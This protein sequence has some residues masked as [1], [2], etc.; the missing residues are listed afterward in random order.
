MNRTIEE[1]CKA[2]DALQIVVLNAW[3]DDRILNEVYGWHHPSLTRHDLANLPRNLSIRL[4]SLSP[5]TIEADLETRIV[6]IPR[7]LHSLHSIIPHMYNGNGAQAIPA[8][9]STIKA[10]TVL[11]DPL[12]SWEVLADNKAMPPQLI[13]KLRGIQA[14]IENIIPEKEVLYSQIKLINDATS[15]A[16]SLPADLQSLTEARKKIDDIQI[17]SSELFNLIDGHSKNSTEMYNQLDERKKE[18]DK[19]V[20]KCEEA[21]RITTTHGLASAFEQRAARLSTTMWV[22]VGGLLSTLIMGALLGSYRIELLSNEL[23]RSNPHWGIIVIHI[24]IS[25]LSIGA[26]IWFAWLATKQIGQRFRLS[27]DYA[28]KASVAKAYEGYRKEAVRIDQS[29][30]SRLF[31]SA[32][33]RLEEAPLRLIEQDAHGSPWHELFGSN[34]LKEALKTTP[35]LKDKILDLVEK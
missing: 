19:L 33:T 18:A 27:E 24:I 13:K 17:K 22:W 4:K 7:K 23:S 32:L 34:K 10:V 31:G 9:I 8:Y 14:E 28:F 11:L 5:E 25:A 6:D 26:P 30:E 16:E 29:F 12:F 35:G 1:I 3:A 21:Y 20:D 2:L 15:T